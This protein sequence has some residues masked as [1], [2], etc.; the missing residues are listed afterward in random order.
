[1]NACP[2]VSLVLC[3]KNRAEQLKVCL[4]SINNIQSTF[5]WDLVIVDNNSED[6]TQQIIDAFKSNT[7]I[8]VQVTIETIKGSSAAKNTGCMLAKGEYIAFTDDDCY[9]QADFVDSVVAV[10][11][12]NKD[13]GFVGGKVL[14]FDPQDMP[15]TIQTH[16]SRIALK[17][18]S[19]LA[20][21]VI[22]G[23][24]FAFRR[25]AFLATGGFDERF[26]AGR[27][28][29]CEDVDIMAEALR[30]GWQGV[31]DP[32]VVVFHHHK[33]RL[34]SDAEKLSKEYDKGRGAYFAKRL[35]KSGTRKI[36]IIA[37][38][39]KVRWQSIST[40]TREISAALE[41]WVEN[42]IKRPKSRNI[43]HTEI[44]E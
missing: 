15:I 4:K 12:E 41:F 31:Y 3:T 43:M 28:Y 32:R 16:N 37:W 34:Q 30:L 10:L 7:D 33:R 36:Y 2:K 38:L 26:G 21:G 25:T 40:S 35:L 39:R 17:S 18:S 1:M 29:P 6:H 24:N 27:K 8:P 22:H 5:A 13:L 9:P 11:D 20:A 44:T 42:V 14:L 19:Y 23:A